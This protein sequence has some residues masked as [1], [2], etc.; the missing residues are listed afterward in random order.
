MFSAGFDLKVMGPKGGS[1]A[2]RTALLQ[3]GGS[4]CLRI[5]GY[6]K[7]LVLAITGHALA[8]GAVMMLAGDVRVGTT[9][10]KAKYGLNEV[11]IGM[12]LPAFGWELARARLA[13]KD[14]SRAVTMGTIYDATDAVSTARVRRAPSH[15]GG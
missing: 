4:L 1:P 13:Q 14:Y 11:A 12:T 2:Q 7:P 6:P 5:F 8:L 15:P 10:P 9:N 3:A